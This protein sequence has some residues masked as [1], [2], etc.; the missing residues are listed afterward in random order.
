MASFT[1]SLAELDSRR[2]ISPD[3]VFFNASGSLQ[4]YIPAS[5]PFALAP[6]NT[7]HPAAAWSNALPSPSYSD[8]SF[9][10]N[11][12]Q[13]GQFP[14]DYT[15]SGLREQFIVTTTKIGS[16]EIFASIYASDQDIFRNAPTSRNKANTA[17]SSSK[18]H[19]LAITPSRLVLCWIGADKLRASSSQNAIDWADH[20]IITENT[21][22][23]QFGPCAAVFTAGSEKHI[24]IAIPGAAGTIRFLSCADNDFPSFNETVVSDM[25]TVSPVVVAL[26]QNPRDGKIHLF[27]LDGNQA[28]YKTGTFNPAAN[29][30]FSFSAGRTAVDN[31]QTFLGQGISAFGGTNFDIS[32][33][34]PTSTGQKHIHPLNTSKNGILPTSL[35]GFPCQF[36][37]Q[38]DGDFYAGL[39]I[40][41][42]FKDFAFFNR[43]LP[44]PDQSFW[45]TQNRVLDIEG[46]PLLN[47]EVGIEVVLAEVKP[48]NSTART[49][50]SGTVGGFRS[51]TSGYR[52]IGDT[53]NRFT[54]NFDKPML[55]ASFSEIIGTDKKVRLLTP[56]GTQVNI[57]YD[58]HNSNELF[59]RPTA[60]LQFDTTYRIS[61][62]S[63]VVDLNGSQIFADKLIPFVTQLS[64]SQVVAEEIATIAVFLSSAY[65]NET[66]LNALKEINASATLYISVEAID[67]A[68]NTIDTTTVDILLNDVLQNTVVLTETSADSGVFRGNYTVSTPAG[69]NHTFTLKTIKN[70]VFLPL[71]VGFPYITA[72]SPSDG[73][74]N[75]LID[76]KPLIQFSEALA[77]NTV[78]TSSIRLN[79]G[80]TTANFSVSNSGSQITLDPDDSS[81]G[82]LRSETDY[83]IGVGYAV[84][85]LA[86]NPF[87]SIPA[88][89]TSIFRTQASRTA[90]LAISDVRLFKDSGFGEEILPGADFSATGTLY[91][92]FTGTDGQELTRD[93]TIASISTGQTA[94]LVET[95]S[96]TG[97]FRGS[98]SFAGLP[99]LFSLQVQ[100]VVTPSASAAL[101]I[102]YPGL[103]PANPASGAVAV[104]LNTTV[105][106][107]ADE[108]LQADQ[109]NNLNVILSLNGIQTDATAS[110]N[111]LT[112]EISIV[113][114]SLLVGE[115]TYLVT[116]MN[117]KDLSGNPQ[118]QN[119]AFSFKTQDV[120]P[121]TIVSYYPANSATGI[122]IDHQPFID[123]SENIAA[124]S[125][126]KNSVKLFRNGN[127]A[128]YSLVVNGARLTIAPDDSSENGMLPES[129]YEIEV[130][131]GVTDLAGNNLVNIP[132]PFR[133]SFTTQPRYTPPTAIS[134]ISLY[135]DPL[136]FTPWGAYEKIPASTTV[137]I[138]LNGTDGAT[139][140][141]D[142]A[143]ITLNLSWGGA[144]DFVIDETASN[145]SGIYTGSFSMQSIPL[146]G[147]PAPQP[148][149]SA[150]ELAFA[151]K[152]APAVTATLSLTFPELQPLQTTVTAI[153]GTKAAAGTTNTRVDS[154]INLSFSDALTDTG[155]PGA[156]ELSSGAVALA[157]ARLLSPDSKTLTLTPAT[158]LPYNSE[159]TVKGLYSDS[160]LKSEEGNPLYRPF[161]FS[162]FTQ[163][164]QTQPLTID[165]IK[166]FPDAAMSPLNAYGHGSDFN[167]TGTLYIE[168]VG[169]DRSSNTTDSTYVSVSTGHT[170]ALLET[171]SNSGVFRGHYA[172][173]NL[174]DGF[175]M[176]VT[177]LTSPAASHS[178]QLT[179]PVLS[180]S[181]PASGAAE[182]SLATPIKAVANEFLDAATIG[183]ATVK[184]FK[185]GVEIPGSV[186]YLAEQLAIEF[187]PADILQVNSVYT[188]TVDGISDLAGN[189]QKQTFAISFTT[190]ATSVAPATI[191]GIAAF[192]D[193]G[194]SAQLADGAGIKPAS[195][196]F[197]AV[198]AV[199]LSPTTIDTTEV[200][201]STSVSGATSRFFLIET[202]VNSGEF[203]GSTTAYSDENAVLTLTSAS[204]P[205]IKT[206]LQT[207][208]LPR[209]LSIQPASGTNQL[210]L[211]TIFNIEAN[212]AVAAETVDKTTVILADSAGLASYTLSMPAADMI[213]IE[214]ELKPA[215]IYHLQ[216]ANTLKDTDGINFD[217]ILANYGTLTP[218]V[219]ELRIFAD[220][221]Y[222]NQIFTGAEVETGQTLYV[223]INAVNAWLS[224]PETATA[225][226]S[227]GTATSTF[228][229]SETSPGEFSGSFVVPAGANK[230]LI[231]APENRPDLAESLQIIPAFMLTSFSP[232]SGSI[233]IP[234]DVWP[235]WNFNRQVDPADLT[236]ANF[237][238]VK[239]DDQSFVPV[240][241][242]RGLTGYQ[243]RLEP[244][245]G[246]LP[247]LKEFEMRLSENVR[248]IAGNVLGTR[249]HTRFTTQPPPPPPSEI[250]SLTNYESD[251]YATATFAVAND[252]S[253][254]LEIV[255]LDTSFSTY[256]TSRVRLESTDR[257]IDGLE[258]SLSEV[259]PP[260]GV[261]RLAVPINLP[262]ETR[263][264][265]I[266]QARPDFIIEI[267]ARLRTGLVN[268]SPASG[269]TALY[270]D[271]PV[272]LTFSNAI[273]SST[274]NNGFA[275]QASAG[276]NIPFTFRLENSARTLTLTPDPAYASST[277]HTFS[278]N[279]G[280][281]D[282]NG[283]YLL[284]E[285][286][287]LTTR[288]ATEASFEIFT[289][290]PPRNA[291]KVSQTGEAV[292]GTV[293]VL[294]S[295]TDMF[296]ATAETRSLD[297]STPSASF[298]IQLVEVS[299]GQF[300]GSADLSTFTE[301]AVQAKLLANPQPAITFNIA[302]VPALLSILPASDSVDIEELPF[303]SANFNRKMA[304]ESGDRALQIHFAGGTVNTDQAGIAT[305]VTTLSWVP[306]MA[307]PAQASCTL[308]LSGITDYLGQPFP[309]YQHVFSTGRRQGISVFS[310]SG[311]SQL[312]TTKEVSFGQLFIEVAAS[313]TMNIA[314]RPFD[315]SL[316]RGTMATQTF[317]LPLQPVS[318]NSG[319]FR[320][321]LAVTENRSLPEYTV[322]M[323]PGEWLEVSSEQLTESRRIFY[324]RH[325]SAAEPQNLKELRFFSDR[326]YLKPVRDRLPSP[327]LYIEIEGEDQNWFTKDTTMVKITSDADTT[328][329]EIALNEISTHSDLFRGFVRLVNSPS[330]GQARNLKVLPGQNIHVTSLT[331]PNVR[332]SIR[333]APESSIGNIAVFPNPAKGDAITFRFNLNFATDVRLEIFDTAGDKIKGF[334]IRGREG[335]NDFR[336]RF[337]RHLANGVYFYRMEI[338]RDD[339]K[340]EGKRKGRGKFA[341]LR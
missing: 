218:A 38:K 260:S 136:L 314:G 209:Y 164:S 100:S 87:V 154:S 275:I 23:T 142:I 341:V 69:G 226:F 284:P 101:Q 244:I 202:T 14:S 172:Y 51:L 173:D 262:P 9:Y 79:R 307:L 65:T 28:Y 42:G 264:R 326:H 81:E 130:N 239:T 52:V 19:S 45:E 55:T 85:D 241:I 337:P 293:Q 91:I 251:A 238:L 330:D 134:A 66:R 94:I 306:L 320:C 287:Y 199:D 274:V 267:T 169:I 203:R 252:D 340:I 289:G 166:L 261:Y 153:D 259:S 312:L 93:S 41:S 270:L 8:G 158:A 247:L 17:G 33:V 49:I 76:R 265:V 303:F 263:I 207:L 210:Y 194:F 220:S 295:C 144:F 319:L 113:P 10:D 20:G 333:Y 61:I 159:I 205:A 217:K 150:G 339:D 146:Y 108:P 137:Y 304:Y 204:N 106:V 118:R 141:K 165:T 46:P 177:S 182:V 305:D 256:E 334:I 331:D 1:F 242:Q 249:L 120:T 266:S 282:T 131:S 279:T 122:G 180:P 30:K 216:L 335:S 63:D 181:Q 230:V 147:I 297:F 109:V 139:Q 107:A 316:K 313:G 72:V 190:Q 123:F 99:H 325:S 2:Y 235:T 250:L 213:R 224:K 271:Q 327:V 219:N 237:S 288:S 3:R 62:A 276:W 233:G 310:D 57:A 255:A 323:F 127:P 322:S 281:R 78:N 77:T 163:A 68:F 148:A 82:Y 95:A 197:V 301:T 248:D 328:G 53:S 329:F 75:V 140:T 155:N 43:K 196:I 7:N 179:I 188:F 227:E 272:S 167:A 296:F 176:K 102:T 299:P 88:T 208:R 223:K 71:T 332:L 27:W 24:V 268:I 12:I 74:T 40:L 26:A 143:S 161:T 160:G 234:A 174:S 200:I 317:M 214:A 31:S 35:T 145:S 111:N 104:P 212:K 277:R 80:G 311:F 324:Y 193:S 110:Y 44:F 115:K 178:L 157:A 96:D 187:R 39:V 84:T 273:D 211:D 128:S 240:K 90:P 170:V 315:L 294:A 278:I 133:S 92:E 73:E 138:R 338:G 257:S 86:G 70:D 308:V 121:P 225:T 36:A 215:T 16:T 18:P 50:N 300:S 258:L 336:W 171:A 243:V 291:Q 67:P 83:E 236:T 292:R 298:T 47:S 192:S 162:F 58:G 25:G 195:S 185:N 117:Q 119:L 246:V 114:S 21:I 198:N 184:L 32:V 54:I 285:T 280:L 89:Y 105:R 22:D 189:P 321:S 64:S 290:L 269:S 59:F 201:L 29:P 11:N 232:A 4:T 222:T 229:L 231:I 245:G 13:A 124:A 168:A 186:F 283:L 191:N 97:V 48:E 98:T 125:V 175:V 6:W 103:T 221:A 152:Q 302:T 37:Y 253:L 318:E 206:S 135:K 56:L 132:E 151:A 126:D 60:N 228:L 5:S 129:E 183:V 116:V 156:I 286:A 149:V 309:D 254:Y 34:L 15:I 112:R